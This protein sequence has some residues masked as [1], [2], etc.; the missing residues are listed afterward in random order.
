VRRVLVLLFGITLAAVGGPGVASAERAAPST[1]QQLNKVV[2]V[3][4][5]GGVPGV[6]VTVTKGKSTIF[7]ALK[8]SASQQSSQ[9][10]TQHT[11]FG[12]G[13][14]TKTF[15]ATAVLQ[16]V[17]AGKLALS[18][19][20]QQWVPNVQQA[21]QI[22]VQMLLNMTSGIYDEGGP[23]SLLSQQVAADPTKVWTPQ[24]IV[25]LAVQQGPVAAPGAQFDYSD[26]NYVILGLIV[27]AVSGQPLGTVIQQQI[28]NPLKMKDTS[29]PTTTSIPAPAATGYALV[30]GQTAT[31]SP[32][33]DPSVL[34]AA[35][36]MVSSAHDLQIWG[37]ALATGK[38]LESATQQQRMQF[39]PTGL[40]Y[41][42][43]PG[44]STPPLQVGYGLG[45]ASSSGYLGHN[46]Q[47]LPPGF[48]AELWY[49]LAKKIT[50]VVLLNAVAQ[51]AQGSALPLADEMFASI[52][53][54][55]SPQSIS[56]SS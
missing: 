15:T 8:G 27:Q 12:I 7:S 54:I 20:I 17:D 38:L 41:A 14:V 32:T 42:P 47:V 52:A 31:P 10:I 16:L 45:L 25:D 23:G 36:A 50:I 19:T 29:L 26:T 46:G 49:L 56:G 11:K 3:A 2:G 37:P 35:G 4:V 1:T 48:S 40:T 44:Y 5:N 34:G 39:A 13:S 22:T 43:L 24:E 55:V 18:D 33:V 6:A 9:P 28:L 51:D 30:A 53:G 21:D